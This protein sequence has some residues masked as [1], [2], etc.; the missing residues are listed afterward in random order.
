MEQSFKLRTKDKHII[1]STINSK[2]GNIKA[3]VF[4]HGLTGHQDEHL[5]YNAA[6]FF[7]PKGFDTI[8]FDLYTGEKKGRCLTTT[9]LLTHAKDLEQIITFAKKRYKRIFVVGHSLGGPT[10]IRAN[11][12]DITAIMLWDPSYRLKEEIFKPGPRKNLYIIPWGT[13]ILVSRKLVKQTLETDKFVHSG[14][15]KPTKIVFAGKSTLYKNWG[16][17]IKII[18]AIQEIHLIK[19]A[20]HCFNQEGCAQKLYQET[21]DWFKKF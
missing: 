1:Y 12:K 9:D 16:K 15:D 6:R 5:F 8:R 19:N 10:I 17:A 3:I 13:E 14:L 20:D 11:T 2:K 21:L 4:V 18:S 7:P